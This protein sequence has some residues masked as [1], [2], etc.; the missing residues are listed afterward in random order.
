MRS[1]DNLHVL[2]ALCVSDRGVG[3]LG[4]ERRNRSERRRAVVREP[5]PS[6]S[7]FDVWVL[8]SVQCVGFVL[9]A[10][11]AY[12]IYDAS[13]GGDTARQTQVSVVETHISTA[14]IKPEIV[15]PP[16]HEFRIAKRWS[17]SPDKSNRL[18]LSDQPRER[19]LKRL[20]E[21]QIDDIAGDVIPVA[22]EPF[23]EPEKPVAAPLTGRPLSRFFS[24]LASLEAGV[25]TKPVTIVHLGDSHIASD[26]LTRGIRR[27]LQARF[28]DAGRGM[29]VPAGAYKYAVADGVTFKRVGHWSARNSFRQ[30]GGPYAL[31]GVRLVTSSRGAKLLL[32]AHNDPFDWG[33]VTVV[34][35]PK[36]GIVRLTA[37]S[38]TVE[39][40]ARAADL[41]SKVVR[42]NAKA[43]KLTVTAGGRGATTV[44]NWS[45]GRDTPGIRYVNFGL[46]GATADVTK[47]WSRQLVAND[48]AHLKPDLI[49]WG[50]G[51]NEGFNDR[52]DLKSYSKTVTSF[53]AYLR[54]QAPDADFLFIGPADS[55]RLPRY[56]RH[57][58]RSASCRQLSPAEAAGYGKLV[59]RRSG[60][61]Q[62][63]HAP[64]KLA[65]VRNFLEGLAAEQKAGYW[66]WSAA[67]GGDCAINRW[68]SQKLA[69]G[70][71]VHLTN[72]GYDRSA[73]LFVDHLVN[74]FSQSRLLA[75]TQQ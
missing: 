33:E 28:G 74:S 8:A 45:I 1:Y 18:D 40:N 71:R 24:A 70:D 48:I 3:M 12:I 56:A 41:G 16:K 35:G 57:L 37:G 36:Q 73:S 75:A 30:K 5:D 9:S 10:V 53:V 62:R 49:V 44:L 26:S 32:T 20:V 66:D 60:A 52:L 47:R 54:E 19:V 15:T 65:A 42:I 13:L 27:R 59:S 72:R 31:S 25:R 63:W 2:V 43:G 68:A 7:A 55:A 21:R 17:V 14:E 11:V 38:E 67:M 22:F 64:P 61:L 39:F 23:A 46:A 6:G 69:A 58:R 51:T 29:M 4:V 50:Y 34:T